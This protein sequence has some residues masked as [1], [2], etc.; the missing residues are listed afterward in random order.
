MRA[1]RRTVVVPMLAVGLALAAVVVS[2]S[3]QTTPVAKA[4]V[5][6]TAKAPIPLAYFAPIENGFVQAAY[7]GAQRGA[8]VSGGKVV[9]VFAAN[10]SDATQISQI[11]DAVTSHKY[12]GLIVYMLDPSIAHAVEAA[13]KAGLKV[14]TVESAATPNTLGNVALPGTVISTTEALSHRVQGLVQLTV[15]ACAKR[16]P[17]NVAYMYGLLQNPSDVAIFNSFK[18]GLKKYSK[19]KIVATGQGMFA[20]APAEAAAANMLVAHP[21]IKVFVTNDDDMTYGVQL[22]A[23]RAGDSGIKLIGVGA[24]V[25]GCAL[26]KSGKWFGTTNSVPRSAG[27]QGAEAVDQAVKGRY[28][29]PRTWDPFTQLHLALVS[30]HANAKD[31]PK[32]WSS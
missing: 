23:E 2:S 7:L 22:A 17:C 27:Y 1:G 15:A 9:Q 29:G 6:S 4:A 3:S 30:T 16:N 12:K 11:E 5:S 28:K 31:C 32:Q 18:A 25:R 21:N 19:I 13:A 20:S 14:A 26:V 24:S 8:A 10:G